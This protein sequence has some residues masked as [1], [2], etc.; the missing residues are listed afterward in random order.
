[1]SSM[2][3]SPFIVRVEA[4]LL[5]TC[6]GGKGVN[7][8]LC[9]CLETRSGLQAFGIVCDLAITLEIERVTLRVAAIFC[10]P[11]FSLARS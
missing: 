4:A 8:G 5:D 11:Y 10:V 2:S 1:M 7:G 6:S 3:L 9:P